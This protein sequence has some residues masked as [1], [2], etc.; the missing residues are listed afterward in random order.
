MIYPDM[1]LAP[2]GCAIAIFILLLAVAVPVR[3]H[4]APF[5]GDSWEA[6]APAH[7]AMDAGALDRLAEG[8]GGRGCVIKDGIMV[9]T[10]GDPSER[11][12]WLSSVKPVFSTLL[13]LAIEEGR[14]PTVHHPIADLGWDLKGEDRDMT[15]VHLMNMTSGYARPEKPG[16]A[17][18]YNDFAIQLYQKSLFEKVFRQ[19]PTEVLRSRLGMLQ[20][21]DDPVFRED[22]PR[23]LAS[24]R[25]FARLAWLWC[26][27]GAWQDRRVLPE[28][29]FVSYMKPQTP[30]DL[31]PT[32]GE[33][34]GDYLEIGSFG[35]GSDHFTAYGAGIYGSNWWFN[36]T[37]R[38]HPDRATWPDAPRDTVMSI[39][40][41]GNNAVI[42]PSLNLV[43][44]SAKGDWGKLAAGEVDSKFHLHIKLLVQAV[45]GPDRP[46]DGHRQ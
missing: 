14:V 12:D 21:Q 18:A 46:E 4:A 42:I 9:K 31:P 36:E 27:N 45:Q 2:S 23:L 37:G 29:Y 3:A 7:L 38:L 8:L 25:D 13:F 39:G 44:V 33:D 19:N 34:T 16:A 40:A 11:S 10:W 41:G 1:L 30:A 35:G 6:R 43:L 17:W 24:A 5:P 28:S 20:F 32:A 15:F 26:Q 22:K